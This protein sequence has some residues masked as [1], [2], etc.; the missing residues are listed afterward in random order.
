[1]RRGDVVRRHQ[2][3][4]QSRKETPAS[5]A[6]DRQRS[7]A[8][9]DAARWQPKLA[10]SRNG[11]SLP[12]GNLCG[13]HGELLWSRSSSSPEE[14]RRNLRSGPA[15]AD[16]ISEPAKGTPRKSFAARQN[17]GRPTFAM[18]EGRSKLRQ[19]FAHHLLRRQRRPGRGPACAG[20]CPRV[21]HRG[22][23]LGLQARHV[24]PFDRSAHD[25]LRRAAAGYRDV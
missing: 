17:Y 24:E 20:R 18:L 22:R 1:M 25:G 15:A 10:R 6:R 23:S 7:A 4:G 9:P 19:Q 14:S 13:P 5:R 16:R 21:I 2:S 11:R 3:R 8:I 12:L